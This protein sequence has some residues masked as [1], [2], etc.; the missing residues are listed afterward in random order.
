MAATKTKKPNSENIMAAVKVL[1]KYGLPDPVSP[2][3]REMDQLG[4]RPQREMDLG[5]I[6]IPITASQHLFPVV[7]LS[8]VPPDQ[9][10]KAMFNVAWEHGR[11]A[12]LCEAELRQTEALLETFPRLKGVIKELAEEVADKKINE[13][14]EN[15]ND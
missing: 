14:R 6:S 11:E 2:F 3:F 8:N 5:R 1:M 9:I 13:F 7:D 12:G 15:Q 4:G 10:L